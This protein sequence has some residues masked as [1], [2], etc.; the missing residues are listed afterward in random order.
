MNQISEQG[1]KMKKINAL[2]VEGLL[3]LAL[4]KF[5]KIPIVI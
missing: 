2:F 3:N 1:D 4:P 5:V